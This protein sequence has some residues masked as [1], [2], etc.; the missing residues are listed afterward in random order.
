MSLVVFSAGL[1]ARVMANPWAGMVAAATVPF[2]NPWAEASRWA[3]LYPTLAATTGLSLA[4]GAAYVRWKHP[5]WIV[6]AGLAAG[7]A[8]GVDFRG[9]SLV[10]AVI[11]L[12]I[13]GSPRRW[14]VLVVVLGTIA[15]GPI[16]NSAVQIA[17]TK[18]TSYAVQTQRDLE[19]RL[20]VESGQIDLVRA[21]HNEV[22][23]SAY[24]T[25]RTIMSPC[26]WAFLADNMDRA[27]DQAPFG[28]WL[29]LMLLP[30]VALTRSWQNTLVGVAVF[31]A[32]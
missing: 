29:T 14:G 19:L 32:A 17:E 31:G 7:F 25:L 24:P 16:A 9:I 6:L 8:W 4:C 3:T 1:G 23:D 22:A 13:L 10:C 26:A 20:A 15:T 11:V 12:G 30:F 2:I 28:V 21:C 5:V 27:K 18:N